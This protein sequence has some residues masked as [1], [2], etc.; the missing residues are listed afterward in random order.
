MKSLVRTI[1]CLAGSVALLGLTGCASLG[2]KPWD[3]AILARNT[4]QLDRNG[5][6]N[7]LDDHIYF[8]K[9]ASTGG[10]GIGG[11]GCGCN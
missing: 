11:G 10:R 7:A 2:A 3:R 6:E 4:M 9:E 1:A 8:S 5:V